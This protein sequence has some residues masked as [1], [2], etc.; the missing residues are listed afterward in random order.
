MNYQTVVVTGGAGFIGS[1]LVDELLRYKDINIIIVDNL[2]TGNLQNLP[3]RGKLSRYILDIS[4]FDELYSSLKNHDIDVIF[5]LAAVT[6]LEESMEDPRKTF[7]TNVVGTINLLEVARRLDVEGFIY[8]SS[9]AVYGEP[10]YLPINEEHPLDPINFYGYT[11]LKGEELVREYSSMYGLKYVILRYFNVYGPR[12]RSGQYSGVIHKFIT[13]LLKGV[14]PIIYGDGSQTRD[15]IHVSDVVRANIISS[16]R[17]V[18]DVFNIGTG[19][20][21]RIIDL[22]DYIARLMGKDK[23]RPVY[24]PRRVGDI[25]RSLSDSKKAFKILGWKAEKNLID[26][27]RETIQWYKNRV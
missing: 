19:V 1:N 2:S 20:E 4:K 17:L 14:T 26:G 27:L 9:V 6:S 8:S 22:L 12:M 18:N 15:F 7:Y 11:K 23:I 3:D 25:Y 24:H 16:L 21:T 10:K 13:S 5:H